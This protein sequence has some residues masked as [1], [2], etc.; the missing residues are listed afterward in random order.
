MGKGAFLDV[1]TE[2]RA[3]IEF[4]SD[5]AVRPGQ[6]YAI[7]VYLT[8]AGT[9]SARLRE[10]S[11]NVRMN[12][13]G[14]P[15]KSNPQTRSADPGQK[16]LVTE[17]T[18]TWPEAIRSWVTTVDVYSDKEEYAESKVVFRRGQ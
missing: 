11:V 17:I 10:V 16:V 18:G 7:K 1:A 8:N 13:Q 4:E 14:G 6:P 15:K 9:K 5:T 3:Q 12:A 2:F